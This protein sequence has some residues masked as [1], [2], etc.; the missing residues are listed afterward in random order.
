MP[1]G[2]ERISFSIAFH[3]LFGCLLMAIIIGVRRVRSRVK[4]VGDPVAAV[5]RAPSCPTKATQREVVSW[6]VPSCFLLVMWPMCVSPSSPSGL[7]PLSL[8]T[9]GKQLTPGTGIFIWWPIVLNFFH[10]FFFVSKSN[11]LASGIDQQV[12][13]LDSQTWP[14][15]LHPQVPQWKNRN[16]S[17]KLSFDLRQHCGTHTYFQTP[18]KIRKL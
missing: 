6:S 8:T 10:T 3:L 15:E 11:Q 18:T 13:A 1:L 16:A 5:S 4:T 7:G 17:W 12:K 14:P 9:R 2:G